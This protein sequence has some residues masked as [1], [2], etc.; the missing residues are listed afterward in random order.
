MNTNL[1]KIEIVD[2]SKK[3]RSK[4]I[5]KNFNYVI[6]NEKI[7][8]L[9]SPN[10]YGKSTLIKAILNIINYRGKIKTDI[11]TYSYLPERIQVPA[12]IKVDRFLSLM[13]IPKDKYLP[14]LKLFNV[15]V[16]KNLVELSKGMRQKVL[17]VNAFLSDADCYIFDE[18][19]NGLDDY[20]C[21]LFTTLIQDLFYQHKLII[22]STHQI[23]K[24][25][26]LEK[27]LKIIKLEE[28]NVINEIS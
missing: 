16:D 11:K 21:E 15:P 1:L 6:D 8:I 22:I 13:E 14:L 23:D 25:K 5:Y 19:L 28:I 9:K 7:N 26:H 10:G 2:F 12:Y 27:D 18:P 3:Y 20:S 17:I 4:N 24:F